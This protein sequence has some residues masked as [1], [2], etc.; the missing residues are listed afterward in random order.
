MKAK[1]FRHF[2]KTAVGSSSRGATMRKLVLALTGLILLATVSFELVLADNPNDLQYY[3]YESNY[4][5]GT[6]LEAWT[7]YYFCCANRW[8]GESVSQSSVNIRE[9]Y[10]SGYGADWCE[11]GNPYQ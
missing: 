6:F 8:G 1:R 7:G 5:S 10:M 2:R 3:D 4:L 11:G 9:I